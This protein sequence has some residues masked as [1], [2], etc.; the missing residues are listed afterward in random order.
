[1]YFLAC[2]WSAGWT[3][4]PG[5][6]RGFIHKRGSFLRRLGQRVVSNIP[7]VG[8]VVA[9]IGAGLGV[10]EGRPAGTVMTRAGP[11]QAIDP[12][13]GCR[14]GF[15]RNASNICAALPA[16]VP[17]ATRPF[18]REL[19]RSRGDPS[20]F[21]GGIEDADFAMLDDFGAARVGRFGAGIEPSVVDRR[22]R[23]CPTGSVLG[24]REA[25]G[26]WLCYNRRDLS[27]KERKWPRGRRPLLTG[28]EMRA[29]S[30]AAAAARKLQAKQKQLQ[31][32][33][34][35]KK[36]AA[37]RAAAPKQLGPGVPRVL[38]IQQE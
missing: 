3:T 28:G 30:I 2:V 33:G 24:K 6:E 10:F 26:S 35:L 22:F 29:I 38:Q 8:G 18:E 23:K 36:P 13:T 12:R 31:E 16:S 4:A 1:M 34:L 7:I 11:Q 19:A 37:R 21:N 5:D 14:P 32:L 15:F 25:D 9:E 20:I 27:N 17:H